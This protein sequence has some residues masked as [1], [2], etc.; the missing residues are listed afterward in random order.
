MPV[1]HLL[2]HFV[3]ELLLVLLGG[4]HERV[5]LVVARV[6]ERERRLRH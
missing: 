4:R 1:G 3:E 2:L 5:E 6:R